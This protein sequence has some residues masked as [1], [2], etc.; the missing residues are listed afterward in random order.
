MSRKSDCMP[1]MTHR[2][3]S[4]KM[5]NLQLCDRFDCERGMWPY[6][7]PSYAIPEKMVRFKVSESYDGRD[8]FCHFHIEDYQFERL[9]ERPESY[10]D[11]LRRYA[12]L[13]A[14]DFSTYTDM[15][16]PMQMWN[17]YRSRALTHYWQSQGLEVIPLIQF[18]DESSY[19]WAFE[20]LPK[21]SV[22]A[23][24]SVGVYRNKTCRRDFARGMEAACKVLEPTDLVWFGLEVDCD[25]N[26]ARVHRY[27]NDNDERLRAAHKRK[28][29]AL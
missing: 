17:V 10:I 2:M 21:H 19:D 16:T 28:L 29:E 12:G 13:I 18:S 26:G 6:V 23:T 1:S 24:S 5:L 20:G 15:P 11:I 14:P 22:L 3:R 27:N 9:W 7:R 4:L 25:T 8:K